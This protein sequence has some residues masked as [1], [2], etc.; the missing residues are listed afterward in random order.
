[1]PEQD[2]NGTEIHAGFEQVGGEG[3]A[4]Q[5]RMNGLGDAGRTGK[6][7]RQARKIVFTAMGWPEAARAPGNNQSLGFLVRQ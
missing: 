3:V 5:M 6:A 7:L 4:E 1:M 2:L